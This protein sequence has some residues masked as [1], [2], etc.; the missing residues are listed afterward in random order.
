MSKIKAGCFFVK[1]SIFSLT[2]IMIAYY[3]QILC[4]IYHLLFLIRI[5]VWQTFIHTHTEEEMHDQISVAGAFSG[6]LQQVGRMGV[7]GGK[8]FS[9]IY[10]YSLQGF[11]ANVLGWFMFSY[12]SSHKKRLNT[13]FYLD[14]RLITLNIY[15]VPQ[16]NNEFTMYS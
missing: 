5:F 4:C 14:R 16:E 13:I 6:I 7:I 10:R 9:D 11:T 2:H 8:K 15:L 12:I 3:M 1:H